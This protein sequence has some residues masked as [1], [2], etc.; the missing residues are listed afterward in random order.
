MKIKFINARIFT[1]NDYDDNN[2]YKILDNHNLIIK[3]NE[4]TF[5]G[6]NDALKK[7][8]TNSDY[9]IKYDRI[10][11]SNK[12]LIMPTFKNAHTHSAMTFLRSYADDLELLTWLGKVQ[13]LERK[14]NDDDIY[15]LTI[16]AIMEYLS[17][18][19]SYCADMFYHYDAMAKAIIDTGFRASLVCSVSSNNDINDLEQE[20]LRY[21]NMPND[22]DNLLDYKMGLHS[23]YT[24]TLEHIKCASE[25][26]HKYKEPFFTHLSETKTETDA[27]I[28]RYNMTPA[29]LFD[30]Y[31]LFDFGGAGYHS[32][33][34]NDEDIEIY[35]KHN[36]SVVTN[37]CSNLKLASGIAPIKKYIDN[38]INISIGT[39]GPASNNALDM[40]REMYLVSCLSKVTTKRPDSI[41]VDNVF[42]MAIKNPAILYGK[43][44]ISCLKVGNLAD[45]QM[46]DL[47][48]PN[49]Q[50][51][52][53]ILSNIIYSG[54]KSNVKMTLVNGKILYED[55]RFNIGIDEYEVYNRCNLILSRIKES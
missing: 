8:E 52:N 15:Y 2:H 49:M 35:K 12:N 11:D 17:S 3:D 53:N 21:T 6:D 48:K 14:L 51:I 39:D 34:L 28:E 40:F 4:I 26:L 54:D 19:T 42:D 25:I 45:I 16:L 46:I 9:D 7:Y 38:G 37:P 22:K 47:S 13:P 23:E 44:N 43:D 27:C 32:V 1:L 55:G 5:I 18:G 29:K 33:Y 31:G 24:N 10:I 30:Y 41:H 20:Y 50:P 36:I